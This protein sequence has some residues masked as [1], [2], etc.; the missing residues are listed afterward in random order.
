MKN[1]TSLTY[2]LILL[3]PTQ[4]RNYNLRHI[5]DLTSVEIRTNTQNHFYP[6]PFVPAIPFLKHLI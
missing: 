4:Q 5:D 6:L 3:T 1:H 2:F